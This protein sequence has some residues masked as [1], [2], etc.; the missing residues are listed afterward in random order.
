MGR[1]FDDLRQS[2]TP[3]PHAPFFPAPVAQGIEH[4]FPKPC[5]AGSN[6]AGGALSRLA[7]SYGA[8]KGLRAPQTPRCKTCVSS[9]Y[10]KSA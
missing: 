2:T 7:E 5:V 4:R 10:G 3:F 1:P 9:A 6:P 8:S